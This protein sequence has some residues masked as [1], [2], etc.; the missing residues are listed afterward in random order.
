MMIMQFDKSNLKFP[1]RYILGLAQTSTNQGN[2]KG[3]KWMFTVSQIEMQI[4][5][6][7]FTFI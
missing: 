1:V 3:I 4:S 5:F 7:L 6:K 2:I